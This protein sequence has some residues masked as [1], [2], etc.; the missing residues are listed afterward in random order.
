MHAV[1]HYWL[2]AAVCALCALV[3]FRLVLS[4]RITLQASLSFLVLLSLGA[5]MALFPGPAAWVAHRLGFELPSNF[6]FAASI[7]ALALLHV[8][9]MIMQS[10]VTLRSIALT[11]ELAIL[12]EKL[13]R[14][15]REVKQK[16]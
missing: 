3:M 15:Q 1:E 5:G 10:R 16:S 9:A 12:Q 4:E 11:Q 7:F 6:F 13:E 14:L 2:F 8:H